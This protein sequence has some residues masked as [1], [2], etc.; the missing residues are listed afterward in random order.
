M[1]IFVLLLKEL[2][3][4]VCSKISSGKCNHC[5][6]LTE[7]HNTYSPSDIED[8]VMNQSKKPILKFT[9]GNVLRIA[10]PLQPPTQ[11][12]D[13]NPNTK[14]AIHQASWSKMASQEKPPMLRLQNSQT[15]E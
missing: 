9:E 6:P 5:C 11:S 15:P 12:P 10:N 8:T 2:H 1:Q 4:I 3:V 13:R 7:K 14:I